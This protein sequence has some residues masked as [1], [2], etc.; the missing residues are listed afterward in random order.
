MN[1]INEKKEEILSEH[2]DFCLQ[3][4]NMMRFPL[5]MIIRIINNPKRKLKDHRLLIQFIN[6]LIEKRPKEELTNEYIEILH[7]DV[8]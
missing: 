3:N 6:K 7:A 2:L 5:H 1:E 4:E 8:E